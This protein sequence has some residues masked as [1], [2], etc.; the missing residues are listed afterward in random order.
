MK[1]LTEKTETIQY[2][3]ALIGD[4]LSP[5]EIGNAKTSQ[6]FGDQKDLR[7]LIIMDVFVSYFN[8]ISPY[9]FKNRLKNLRLD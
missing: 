1:Y 2:V 3:Q 4:V 9:N 8:L 6:A 5:V 7:R